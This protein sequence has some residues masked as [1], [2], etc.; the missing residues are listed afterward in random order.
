[1]SFDFFQF[2]LIF[3]YPKALG[4]W[5]IWAPNSHIHFHFCKMEIL[6]G[7]WPPKCPCSRTV[8]SL[9]FPLSGPVLGSLLGPLLSKDHLGDAH[10]RDVGFHPVVQ[11]NPGLA[12]GDVPAGVGSLPQIMNSFSQMLIRALQ[13]IKSTATSCCCIAWNTFRASE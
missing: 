5:A 7:I 2:R 1:M 6:Y 8:I 3:K 12:H 9:E 13:V 10:A 4:C 11:T